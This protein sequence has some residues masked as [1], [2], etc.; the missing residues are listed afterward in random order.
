MTVIFEEKK[1]NKFL[2]KFIIKEKNA[3]FSIITVFK[4][5]IAPFSIFII[6]VLYNYENIHFLIKITN[7]SF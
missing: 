2:L 7:E 5:Q 6:L 1:I 4:H 3:N